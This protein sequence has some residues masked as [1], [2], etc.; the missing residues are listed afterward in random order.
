MPSYVDSIL[1]NGIVDNYLYARQGLL[2]EIFDFFGEDLGDVSTAHEY[3]G[4]KETVDGLQ[5]KHLFDSITEFADEVIIGDNGDTDANW[6]QA[7]HDIAGWYV[8]NIHEY[9]QSAYSY[10]E[11]VKRKVRWDCSGFVTACLWRYGALSEIQTPPNSHMYVDDK[12][13]DRLMRAAGFTKLR[14]AW[15]TAQPY[16]I[17]SYKGH[18]EIYNGQHEGRHTSWAWG[19]CHDKLHGGLPC[20]TVGG[21]NAPGTRKYDVI[22]RNTGQNYIGD[23]MGDIINTFIS[24]DK[25]MSIFSG[26]K[27]A[28]VEATIKALDMY[29]EAVGLTAKGKL[30]MVAQFAH[31]SANFR[32]MAEYASGQAYEG[33]RDLGNIYPG[34]G[35]RFK[36]R[37]PI[38]VTGRNNYQTIMT[39]AW[40]AFGISADIMSR[41]QLLSENYDLGAAASMGWL[42]VT[43][44]GKRAVKAANEGNVLALT[45]AIN[46]GINGLNDRQSKTE[47]LLSMV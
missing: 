16:D 12:N 28:I 43:P 3:Y 41:P 6:V 27:R 45:K 33:R 20:S 32:T 34:D 36:G 23:T 15:R 25:V 35:Q 7:V 14:F 31:E 19:S 37:G 9:N 10:C 4:I 47:K 22:W 29:G 13:I 21:K 44:N 2:T 17:I 18:V 30:Y 39:K 1:E 38:Q 24:I 46:G 26:A 8:N 42:L 11:L 40:P 5:E